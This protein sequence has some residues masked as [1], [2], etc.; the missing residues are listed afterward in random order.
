MLAASLAILA[1]SGLL[2]W[3]AHPERSQPLGWLAAAA[4]LAVLIWLAVALYPEMGQPYQES[5]TWI[6]SLGVEISFRLDGLAL[7]FTFIILIIGSA[8]ALYTHFYLHEDD[9]QGFFY[10]NLFLFM[11]SMLG[12][13]WTD[14]ALVLFVFWEG[15]TITSYLMIGHRH[16][17]EDSQRAARNA[18]VITGS[19]G[20]VMLA[21]LLMLADV[22]GSHALSHWMRADLDFSDP[23]VTA[24]MLL[25]LVGAFT[26]SGQ[27]PLHFW[28]PG[29]MAAPTPASAYLHSATMVKAGV[30]LAARFHPLFAEHPLWFPLL[31]GFG[32]ATVAV[33]AVVLLAKHDLKAILAYATLM[34][35]GLL[36][37][38]LGMDSEYAMAAFILGVLAHAFYKGPLFLVS[39]LVEHAT[40]TR[41]VRSLA[42]LARP[43]KL[44]F[45]I[46]LLAALS[47]MGV[48]LWPGFIA[49]EY[50]LDA[51]LHWDAASWDWLG[52]AALAGV[53]LAGGIFVATGLIFLV[54][55]FLRRQAD[56]AHTVDHGH[57]PPAGM[58]LGPAVLV[59]LGCAL[60]FTLNTWLHPMLDA[61]VNSVLGYESHIHF[62][63][64][65]GLGLP[66]LLSV[67]AL[68]AGA[69]LYL[70][71]PHLTAPLRVLTSSLPAGER[72][73][74]RTLQ[75]LDAG[76]RGVSNG[77]QGLSLSSHIAVVLTAAILF[78]LLA[79]TQLGLSL[80]PAFLRIVS[81]SR[82]TPLMEILM[83]LLAVTATI[84]VAAARARLT[85]VIAL[86]VV[87]LTV[88]MWFVLFAAPDLALTQLLVEVLLFVLIILIL[89]KLPDA[90][91]PKL[92][93]GA[94]L[95]N[96]LISLGTGLLGFLLV[97]LTAGRPFF[98]SVS[99]E[100]LR[101]AALGAHGGANVVNVILVD[102]RGF[103]TFGEMTVVAVAGLGVYSLVRAYRFRIR[104]PRNHE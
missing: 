94:V 93:Q 28:L 9:R 31:V 99:E 80:H 57:R 76:A 77:L 85:A 49:K 16:G 37:I 53:V 25:I 41:D 79:W 48:P 103:D 24:A 66:L 75:A 10:A 97:M 18:L 12:I 78:P 44:L 30:F 47:L 40:S 19:G 35:L 90:A 5:W 84:A 2:L 52:V 32:L 56:D 61:A 34:Q 88:T 13:V 60:P 15:T 45:G 86:S 101:T 74:E 82:V 62:H 73:M 54:K 8:V 21:G 59:I 38:A 50:L 98:P 23:T 81:E 92:P 36:F 42:G 7:L 43:Y 67:V 100:L 64:W 1:L 51:L 72:W 91:L 95:R 33:S 63:V 14:N 89:Y 17:S 96:A 6:E 58:A 11:A 26:K 3:R 29:A 83:A 65:S 4:P 39:G 102:F 68:G 70:A 20:L 55:V 22:T 27:F 69:A 46:T 104:H 71:L 87:G